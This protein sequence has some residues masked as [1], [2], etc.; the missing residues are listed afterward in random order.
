VPGVRRYIHYGTIKVLH[1]T[2]TFYN[3]NSTI[4][5]TEVTCPTP[6]LPKIKIDRVEGVQA[7][8]REHI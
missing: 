2:L 1:W 6:Y 4:H 8:L 3:V 5:I 7:K